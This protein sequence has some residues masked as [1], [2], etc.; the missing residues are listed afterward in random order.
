MGSRKQY[1]WSLAGVVTFLA[2]WEIGARV[3]G[4][5][6]IFPGPVLVIRR[7]FT[8]VQTGRFLGALG[9]SFLRVLLGILLSVPLG[10]AVGIL[11]GLDK[12]VNAFLAPLFSVIAATP[13]MS[14]ILIA[15]LVFGSER[16]P[17]FTAFLM[18][19]PVMAANTIVGI[20]SVDP[21]LRELFT[22]YGLSRQETIRRLYI[23][24]IMPFILGGMRS[25]LSLCWK[26]VV[27]SEVLV[28]P[29]LALGTGMQ[30]AK[31]QLETPE[32]F[33]W[34]L[35]TVIAAAFTEWAVS[36]LLRSGKKG[37]FRK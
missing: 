4:S 10:V 35:A 16:T 32:L 7:F 22:L 29:L 36:T 12:R 13:V 33:A 34:T 20:R 25:S 8:L 6:L 15:F 30:R 24:A 31:A 5:Y 19:F 1:W 9:G 26:V 27:A 18:V 21:K 3:S 28:Q 14:V 17:V 37:R 23:P 11:A 2:V